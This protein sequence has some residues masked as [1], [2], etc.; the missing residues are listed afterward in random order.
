LGKTI[1]FYFKFEVPFHRPDGAHGCDQGGASLQKRARLLAGPRRH[2]DVLGEDAHHPGQRQQQPHA[3]HLMKIQSNH[4]KNATSHTLIVNATHFWT[5]TFS[6]V[7]LFSVLG[8]QFYLSIFSNIF[9]IDFHSRIAC[10]Q[11]MLISGHTYS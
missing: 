4:F 1:N 5:L 8:I 6:E 10:P 2:R 7:N 11:K 3:L 9:K